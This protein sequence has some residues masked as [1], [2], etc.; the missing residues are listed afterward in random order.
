MYYIIRSAI[1]LACALKLLISWAV[2]IPPAISISTTWWCSGPG[3]L[4]G[5][6]LLSDPQTVAIERVYANGQLAADNGEYLLPIPEIEYPQWATDTMNVG[7]ELIAADFIITAPE[8]RETVNAALL[9]PFWFEPEI[10]TKE[11]PV[12]EDGTVKADP[13]SWPD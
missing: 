11:L 2:I 12:A 13:G 4:C 9:E 6:C 7:R 1:E 8:G 5:C 10:I 3:A